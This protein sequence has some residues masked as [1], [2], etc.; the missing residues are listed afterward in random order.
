MISELKEYFI[1]IYIV[2]L[3][4]VIVEQVYLRDTLYSSRHERFC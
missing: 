2:Q 3:D 1:Y 4:F